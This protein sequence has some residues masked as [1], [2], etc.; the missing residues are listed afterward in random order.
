MNK[1]LKFG[2]VALGVIFGL[3]AAVA[4]FVVA[5]FNPNDYKGHLIEAVRE[6]TQRT[7]TIDGDIGLFFFPRVGAELGKVSLSDVGSD[8]RFTSVESARV[9]LA[10]MPLL[11][12][13]VVV[14]EV[15]VSGLQATLVKRQDGTTNIDDLLGKG[16]GKGGK[17]GKEEVSGPRD[18]A[19]DIA[20]V[21]VEKTSLS[22]RDEAT[23]AQYLL[24]DL[25]FTTGRIANNL[26]IPI[27]LAM[28]V[29]A[30]EPKLEIATQLKG[31]LTFDLVKK[32][33]KMEGMELQVSGTALDM[34]NLNLQVGGDVGADM[35]SQAFTVENLMAKGTGVKG[36]ETFEGTLSLPS[37]EGSRQAFTCRALTLE[38]DL[39]QPGQELQ[40]KLNS[41]LEGNIQA[42]QFTM[43][44]LIVAVSASGER[45]P[46][47]SVHSEMKGSL[48]VDAA[49]ESVQMDLAGGL[50]QSQVKIKV[51][52]SG[53][54]DPAIQFDVEADQFD[55]DLYLPQKVENPAEAPK[56]KEEK[57]LDLSGLHKLNLDGSLRVGS[58]KAANVNLA[59][60]RVKVKARDG[61]LDLSPLTANLYDG[62]M[63]GSL[64]INALATPGISIHQQLTGIDVAPLTKAA[65]NIDSLEG[66]GTVNLDLTMQGA[67]VSE[68]KKSMN[69]II[70][71][72][73]VDGALKGI[74]IAK[75]L[76]EAKKVLSMGGAG[77][78]TQ[79]ADKAEKTDFSELKATFRVSKGVAHNDDLS[80]KSPLLR[81]RGS[82]NIDLGNDRMDYLAK[83]TL[84]KTLEGQGGQ[85]SIGGIMVPV[86]AKGPFS[87]VQYTL[88][89]G[90]MVR[91]A[92]QQKIETEVKRQ[93]QDQLK[94][95]L[96]G[97][98][99]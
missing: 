39:K 84:A 93:V 90:V 18:V 56:A 44:D 43:S 95:S 26:P 12:R 40:V 16:P 61:Q 48:Q 67:T 82:G 5:T 62:S 60:L 51:G 68:M 41:P 74:N 47:K 87:N 53:F 17:S 79:L 80:L 7:L 85:E 1:I 98:F 30:N 10:L 83:A 23:G 11:S 15:L 76:R 45:L 97:L 65:A 37:L 20:A 35:A 46:D 31:T 94:G 70:A 25:S 42:R 88:D 78:Q 8:S 75:H 13:Q 19:F 4:A 36:A 3:A 34:S 59:Q 91:E 32:Y 89:F 33:G 72:N 66:K 63:S 96:K 2:L 99:K 92:A 64:G 81:V 71:V 21:A 77:I 38:V 49:K 50:L 86:R 9:S 22:Y 14:D 28:V 69:G 52:V 24:K 27:S 55:A 6:R 29:Q 58:L 54:A 73:L 57:A